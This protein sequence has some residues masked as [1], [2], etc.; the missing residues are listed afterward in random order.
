MRSDD[1]VGR[2]GVA[3]AAKTGL[4]NAPV[5]KAHASRA[6]WSSRAELLPPV[7]PH[8]WVLLKNAHTR[9]HSVGSRKRRER[10]KCKAQISVQPPWTSATNVRVPLMQYA[11]TESGT[12]HGVVGIVCSPMWQ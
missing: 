11:T 7:Q 6:C 4:K 12:S 2:V 5:H 3:E 10:E 8:G 1:G 9:A